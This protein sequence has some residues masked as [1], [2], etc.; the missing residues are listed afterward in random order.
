VNTMNLGAFQEGQGSQNDSSTQ[1]LIPSSDLN[2]AAAT[3][4]KTYQPDW[5]NNVPS[6]VAKL[7]TFRVLETVDADGELCQVLLVLNNRFAPNGNRGDADTMMREYSSSH[8]PKVMADYD[9]EI[10]R[11]ESNPLKNNYTFQP[12]SFENSLVFAS[13]IPGAKITAEWVKT[14]IDTA[15]IAAFDPASDGEGYAETEADFARADEVLNNIRAQLQNDDYNIADDT[16]VLE[17]MVEGKNGEKHELTLFFSFNNPP[18]VH[19]LNSGNLKPFHV[20]YTQFYGDEGMLHVLDNN[21]LELTQLD[22]MQLRPEACFSNE[23]RLGPNQQLNLNLMGW[24]ILPVGPF[25]RGSSF[26]EQDSTK[27]LLGV[28]AGQYQDTPRFGFGMGNV[29]KGSTIQYDYPLGAPVVIQKINSSDQVLIMPKSDG[30]VSVF[31]N[32]ELPIYQPN[33]NSGQPNKALPG[34]L[35]GITRF[36]PGSNR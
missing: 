29:D 18:E 9:P 17:L 34:I 19:V 26:A 32:G 21:L 8:M 15:M 23:V 16:F 4:T 33:K 28:R 30:S 36:L 22:Y 1:Q 10:Y 27:G 13:N 31:H 11:R 12:T 24:E 6:T 3:L 14:T 2:L 35:S 25:S 20:S 7:F 5:V